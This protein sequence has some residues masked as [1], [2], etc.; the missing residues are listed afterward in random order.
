MKDVILPQACMLPA[1]ADIG[2]M[3]VLRL[4]CCHIPG[5]FGPQSADCFLPLEKGLKIGNLKYSLIIL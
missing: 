3:Q 1:I 4:I 2:L 5:E